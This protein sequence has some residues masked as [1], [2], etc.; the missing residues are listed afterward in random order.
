MHDLQWYCKDG[1]TWQACIPS[2]SFLCR[3]G[4][5][6]CLCHLSYVYSCFSEFVWLIQDTH[7]PLIFVFVVLIYIPCYTVNAHTIHHMMCLSTVTM[8]IQVRI[9][10]RTRNNHIYTAGRSKRWCCFC[11]MPRNSHFCGDTEAH[12]RRHTCMMSPLLVQL[13]NAT[14]VLV[15][16]PDDVG[17]GFPVDCCHTWRLIVAE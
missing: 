11:G 7:I 5:P 12:Y 15:V 2:A 17:C 13:V 4:C 14:H 10:L 6:L 8:L 16:T 9:L 1:P 3:C